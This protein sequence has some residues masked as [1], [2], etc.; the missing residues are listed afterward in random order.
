MNIAE[1]IN[2]KK[3]T[4]KVFS[5]LLLLITLIVIVFVFGIII[6]LIIKG[7]S[8]LTWEFLTQKPSGGMKEG[9]ISTVIIGTLYLVLGTLILSLPIG[10]LAAV[11]LNEYARKNRLTRIIRLSIVNM[12]GVPSVVFG[13]FGLGFFV[14][15]LNFGRSIIAGSLT[16]ALLILPTIIT[17][18]EEA[19]K[20]VPATYRHASL[21]LGATKWQTI[22]KIV[23]PRAMPGIITGAVLGVG[24]AAGETAPILF[25]AAAFF[26]PNLPKSVFSQ[27]MALPYHLYVMVTQVA[28]AP[29]DKKWGTALVLLLIVLFFASIATAIRTRARLRKKE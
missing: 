8:A 6:Y 28:D 26:Q 2:K 19:L 27:V 7:G 1:N 13:L 3:L 14:I 17:S 12:A 15:F 20:S 22:I 18:T 11:Y 25:T 5:L 4:Q 24:R 16:L 9:G 23:L 29:D 10:I 21:A